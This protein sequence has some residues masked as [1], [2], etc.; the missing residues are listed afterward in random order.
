ML[1]PIIGMAVREGR[2]SA[3]KTL[4]EL[5]KSSGV[6]TAM[7]SKIERGQ[8][9]GS[10]ATLQALAQAI[11]VPIINFFAETVENREISHVRS[12]EGMTVER[13]GS[14]YG[15]AYKMI[16]KV[17]SD[18]IEF[19]TFLITLKET[20]SGEPVFQHP[21][22][23]FIRVEKGSMTYR[24]GSRTFLLEPGDSLTFETDAPHGPIAL[25]S[26]EVVFLTVIARAKK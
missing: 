7:I 11:G 4:T 23:E 15:H 13:W 18:Q 9:S 22:V 14:T 25:K 12:G 17:S 10:I 16:G 2:K 21:G 26:E 19:E 8:V 1:D 20:A 24:C 3:G 5:S 6:S